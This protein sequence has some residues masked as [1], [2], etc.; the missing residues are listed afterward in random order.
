[1]QTKA[2]SGV[3]VL[4]LTQFLAGPVCTSTLG[5]L[6]AEVIK[7]ERPKFGEQGR[8]D[9]RPYQQGD[10]SLKWAILQCNKNS[11][12][13][14]VKSEEGKKLLEELI[15]ISD[16]IVENFAPGTIERLGF[17]WEHIHEL[18]P[19]IIFAQIK[20]YNDESDFAKFPAM[21]GPVQ[22]TGGLAAMTGIKGGAP[23][24][25]NT[26][27]AD[28]PSGM[29]C[30]MGILA[31]LYQR[32]QT[33][34]GQQVRINMQEV[35]MDYSRCNFSTQDKPIPRGGA[36]IM[37]GEQA[38]RGMFRCKPEYEGDSDNFVF[39]MVRDSPKQKMWKDFCDVIGRPEL[40]EDPRFVNGPTR[41]K[42][43]AAVNEITENWT[44][45]HSKKEVMRMLCEKMLPAGAVMG[46]PDFLKSEDLYNTGFLQKMDQPH[47]GEITIPSSAIHLSDSPVQV[48]PAP[49]LGNATEEVYKKLLGMS[50]ETYKELL[51]KEVI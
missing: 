25:S 33:G 3:R 7:I 9:N 2:L 34:V 12:T 28:A 26:A 4:D 50:D 13:L 41:L 35:L 18:N 32:E 45:Q 40:F 47:L 21:D 10:M 42:N 44:S 5:M 31:A 16:V 24:I 19:R 29:Y 36:M 39:L 23:L 43:E 49:D 6:G 51:E 1:M 8:N 48:S 22:A 15:K 27:L 37:A 30:V 20:G 38:P 11:V 14:N 17:S 46:V